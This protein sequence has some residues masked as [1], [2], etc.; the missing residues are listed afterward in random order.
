MSPSTSDRYGGF[1]RTP[2]P[3]PNPWLLAAILVAL[4]AAAL[5]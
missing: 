1:D 3:N 2:I 5:I 4:L